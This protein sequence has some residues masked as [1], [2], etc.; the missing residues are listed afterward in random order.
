MAVDRHI[1]SE[2]GLVTLTA[3]GRLDLNVMRMA[4]DEMIRDP[5]FRPG[6]DIIWDLR[7]ADASSA[8]VLEMRQLAE[9]V[10]VRQKE[11]GEHYKVAVVVKRELDYGIAKIYV[12][13]ADR[14]PL[15]FKVFR[16][17]DDAH[18]WIKASSD[19]E[20]PASN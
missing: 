16:S 2:S 3:T 4:I 20:Q 9:F 17:I 19:D 5:D 7:N 10:N 12:A 8:T 11:R 18:Q 14:L 13:I 1:N 15:Q 6:I